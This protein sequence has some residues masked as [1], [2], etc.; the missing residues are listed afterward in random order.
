MAPK[1]FENQLR[2]DKVTES[3][4]VG[5][6]LRHSVVFGNICLTAIFSGNEFIRERHPM[7]EAI[8]WLIL[9]DNWKTERDR[10]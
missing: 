5:R 2:F 7:S 1:S 6:F 8:I 4:K 9:S 3:L 10:M